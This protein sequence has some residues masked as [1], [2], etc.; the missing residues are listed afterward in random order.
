MVRD[1]SMFGDPLCSAETV[2]RGDFWRFT[3]LT[4]SLIRMEYSGD[5]IFEDRATQ[6]V[7]NRRFPQVDF[8]VRRDENRLCIETAKLCL[9]YR[10]GS[11]SRDTLK[12]R[13]EVREDTRRWSEWHFGDP[14][15]SLMGT[16]RTLDNADGEIPL[17]PGLISREG[18]TVLDDSHTMVIGE[19]GWVLPRSCRDGAE[20]RDVYF[21][22]YGHRYQECIQ[23]FYRLCGMT[24]LLPRWA[25]GNWWSRYH[26]YTEAEYRELITRFQEEEIP[27]SVA[28]I[29]MDWHLVN[30]PE[31]Y[32]SG[33]T[34]YTWNRELFPQP[35]VFLA[36]LHEQGLRVTLN[37]H[38]ADGVRAFEEIYPAMAEALSIDPAGK[39][40]IPF[41]AADP[42]F[43]EAYFDVL[44]HT[45]ERDGVDF[46]WI[47]WQ[48]GTR[49]K[50]EGLDPLWILN[51]Y[52]YLDS[53][54]EGRGGITFSRYAGPGGHRYPVGF[55]GDTVT[56]WESLA[57]QPCFTA[58]ASNIGYSW[59]SHDIGGHMLGYRDDELAVRWIQLGVFSPI[60]RLHS[61]NNPFGGK[62][63]WN[64]SREAE[65]IMKDY[66]RL[67]HELIPYLHTMN[68]N[69]HLE[70][71]PLI[72]PL[73]WLEPE[74]D[75]AYEYP[76]EFYFGSELLA[77]PVT[78]PSDRRTRLGRVGA[79]LPAGL[80]F[81]IRN[82]RVYRGNR[83]VVFYRDLEKIPVL[84]KAGGILVRECR[85]E[86]DHAGSASSDRVHRT[87]GNPEQLTA[88]LF[89][90]ADG[91][92]TLWENGEDRGENWASTRL[93]LRCQNGLELTVGPSEGNLGVIPET[94]SWKLNFRNIPSA[95]AEVTADGAAVGVKA[96]YSDRL[97]TLSLELPPIAVTD[98]LIIR[99]NGSGSI[100]N[101]DCAEESYELLNRAQISYE[102]KM[103]LQGLM[104]N[105]NEF[106]LYTLQSMNLD[107]PLFGALCEILS[108]E[109]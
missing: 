5:G 49:T 63:P 24:P 93:S 87:A 35:A 30:I 21:F 103:K 3:V 12:I 89:P 16:A 106:T 94:R 51:H 62:E 86:E 70:G 29:D 47:D 13:A 37:V 95:A 4:P 18:C 6:T 19:D 8:R 71:I 7:M 39:A 75:K 80:W 85:V 97:K 44:Y 79:W 76:N 102:L 107:G 32:G 72:R 58:S 22:G 55:S 41:D 17:E 74:N 60:N 42:A 101:V 83:E 54:R 15:K 81:D 50:I 10:Y 52:H 108:T 98:K 64:F 48:Q 84:A 9:E 53:R 40:P 28:V 109:T 1:I 11:F 27:F 78:E 31:Q 82:G 20:A 23:D 65:W 77:A 33:W 2:V 91:E 90:G 92:F 73:Y 56:T 105:R 88:D 99:L 43:M 38:P 14:V 61:T 26:E 59:W 34:G 25:L 69:T 46:W 68:R 104:E 96:V 57:F 67:R 66:L 45:L 100:V 36:W